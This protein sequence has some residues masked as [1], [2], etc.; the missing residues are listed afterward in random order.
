MSS[1][2]LS[3]TFSRTLTH[4]LIP[5]GILVL[6]VFAL[7]VCSASPALAM[8]LL[9]DFSSDTSGS[10]HGSVS[11]GSGGSFAI[12]GGSL[13]ITPSLSNTPRTYTVMRDDGGHFL[14]VGQQVSVEMPGKSGSE[15]LFLQLSTSNEQPNSTSSFGYRLRRDGGSPGLLRIE[16]ISL[17]NDVIV[18]TADDPN[19]TAPLTVT[20]RRVS[21]TEF[22]FFYDAGSGEVQLGGT[23]TNPVLA[24][25]SN[26]F[27]GV[28]AFGQIG[29][30]HSFDD[31]EISASPV[32]LDDF[33]S[34]TSGSYH[35]SVSSGSGGSFAISGGSL[36]ITPS[37]SNTPRTYTVMRDDGGHFLQVGQQ[38]SVEMPGKSGSESL[39]LQLSTSKEQPNS[40]SSFGYRL[41]RDGGSP[42]LLR[43][44]EI[45]LNNDVIV[46]TA[47]D[48]N[49]TAPLTV[50][51]RR[52][53]ETEFA[54]FYVTGSGE[55][56]LGGTFTNPALAGESNLF[57]GV[58]AFGALERTYSF[59]DLALANVN[60]DRGFFTGDDL[61]GLVPDRASTPS[62]RS[63][64][65]T[66][67]RLDFL[68]AG[69]EESNIL[70][71]MPIMD[72]GEL[73]ATDGVDIT[74]EVDWAALSADNDFGIALSDGNQMVGAMLGDN[75]TL[76]VLDGTEIPP[77]ARHTSDFLPS[78]GLGRSMPMTVEITLGAASSHLT[79][80]NGSG[81][82]VSFVVPVTFNLAAGI[83]LLLVG[84]N[85]IEAYGVN[86]LGFEVIA[87]D[88]DVDNDGFVADT[89]LGLGGT[90]CN[91][92]DASI[93]PGAID[94]ED[95]VDNNCDGQVDEGND[96][97]GADLAGLQASFPSGRDVAVT[98]TRLD[99]LAT[100]GAES[101]ILYRL[102]II[103]AGELSATDGVTITLEVDW[104][105]LSADND[106]GIALSDG[107]Q[108]VGAMLGDNGTLWVL[109]RADTGTNHTSDFL[110]SVG[111][112]RT[113]PMTVEITLGAASSYLTVSNGAGTTV[114]FVVPVTFN[115][116]AGI[117]LLLVGDNAGEAYGVNTL[118]FEVIAFD[119]DIDNDGFV[120]DTILGLGGTDCNDT[121]ASIHPN[122]T[123]V[124][125]GIDNN[126]DGHVDE[127]DV[128]VSQSASPS[129]VG[130]GE[131]LTY[132]LVAPNNGPGVA[133]SVEMVNTLSP[134]VEFVSAS[135]DQGTCAE[136][137]GVVTCSLGDIGV[138]SSAQV[139]VVTMTGAPGYITNT[140]SITSNGFDFNLANN[141]SSAT[142]LISIPN[143]FAAPTSVDSRSGFYRGDV[144]TADLDG[145]GDQ[146][147]LVASRNFYGIAWYEN[148]DG[149]GSFGTKQLIDSR[150][151]VS[152]YAADLDGD[153][154]QDVLAGGRDGIAWYENTGGQ[155]I[156]SLWPQHRFPAGAG[157]V[158][159]V[160]AADLDGDGGQD[161]L[162]GREELAGGNY[163]I[164]WYE[165]IGG[166]G[167][168]WAGRLLTARPANVM[169][170]SAADMDGD[171]DQD[172][173]VAAVG[174]FSLGADKGIAWYENTG[175]QGIF[176]LWPRH[177]FTVIAGVSVF[178]ADLDGDQDQ[179][180]VFVGFARSGRFGALYGEVDWRE[181]FDGLGS[182]GF[183]LSIT[184]PRD[185][186]VVSSI[187]SWFAQ[188][189]FYLM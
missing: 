159:S 73:S 55:V 186:F 27:F 142:G 177:S 181:N 62:A 86:T 42:G 132:T 48:P 167:I 169:S 21:E 50:T 65:V 179:D 107:N 139:S 60:A 83:D 161:V 93:H 94:V 11:S 146:D 185:G 87:F 10:Y 13:T 126:C 36:T 127:T 6:A 43:I 153:G 158:L 162:A 150:S 24:G 25:E 100:G 183:R 76:W 2:Q 85:A 165:N 56:Q 67:T 101:D 61:A 20:A 110:P 182:L 81:G 163:G 184:E 147:I 16:E 33:S 52:V 88:A 152:V 145:D 35:G 23:F 91:D 29:A 40:T 8:P 113:L 118:G 180:M 77:G 154:D 79:V 51:A 75:G 82:T 68:A 12:S 187:Y 4:R 102:P 144:H 37:L 14:Q 96:F 89:I 72:A 46:H 31:L 49:E 172:V 3:Q 115:L 156:F 99:F 69:G 117:D 155:G 19:E 137:A 44:E 164:V 175:G 84:D 173:L 138:G 57:F 92:T 121:D 124:E 136:A 59:D 178:A 54:F 39:F 78:V 28:E 47:D 26:L 140:V 63:T 176:S 95:G 135:P 104:T 143:I 74:L 148:T 58:E 134:G 174:T 17:N 109:D 108:M 131:F 103:N 111:L 32:F 114:S 70:Y 71:R 128:S 125:D 151:A 90:D 160:Y 41:R 22:V 130:E 80:S 112:G 120:A 98:G 170:V 149:R 188:L 15:S 9:D 38:V 7:H 189:G 18:H 5:A 116:A 30:T 119:A 168:S 122:A 171:G 66:G 129:P 64:V 166:Q 123:E 105:A 106:F 157:R 133:E 1:Q 141:T 53:S 34:D 45:S 97:T